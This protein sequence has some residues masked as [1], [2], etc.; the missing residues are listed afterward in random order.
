[1]PIIEIHKGNIRRVEGF[2]YDNEISESN[3]FCTIHSSTDADGNVF[4]VLTDE[5]TKVKVRCK[6]CVQLSP[7]VGSDSITKYA[8]VWQNY[9]SVVG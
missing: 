3:I 5:N 6:G 2:W 9:V 4:Y 7:Y 1:M 8:N